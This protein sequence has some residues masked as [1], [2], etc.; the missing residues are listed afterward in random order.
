MEYDLRGIVLSALQKIDP[1][2]NDV[3]I[4]LSVVGEINHDE[5]MQLSRQKRPVRWVRS[6]LPIKNPDY[7]VS[8]LTRYLQSKKVSQRVVIQGPSDRF[9]CSY[10]SESQYFISN[11]NGVIFEGK[12][13]PERQ[14]RNKL[15]EIYK[16][17]KK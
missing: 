9:V 4:L 11:N 6:L 3:E 14:I 10:L 8:I 5:Q 2:L 1:E 12:S 15:G 13:P 17:S 16:N 7:T